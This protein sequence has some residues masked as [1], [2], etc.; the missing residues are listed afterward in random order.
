MPGLPT[1]TLALALP[2]P[3]ARR[4]TSPQPVLGTRADGVI[5]GGLSEHPRVFS[6][7]ASQSPIRAAVVVLPEPIM[8]SIKISRAAPTSQGYDAASGSHR[9]R[10]QSHG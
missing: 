6:W 7:R 2:N 5:R 9:I 10:R 1:G 4:P 3:G 8:P